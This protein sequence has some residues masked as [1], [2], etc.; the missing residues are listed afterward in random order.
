[1][2]DGQLFGPGGKTTPEYWIDGL[3]IRV[4]AKGA[5]AENAVPFPSECPSIP[6]SVCVPPRS[7]DLRRGSIA[8]IQGSKMTDSNAEHRDHY[9][10]G[11]RSL[12]G[13]VSRTRR[14]GRT[15]KR[16]VSDEFDGLHA[17][18]K[19]AVKGALNRCRVLTGQIE[20][21]LRNMSPKHFT[22][23]VSMADFLAS[24]ERAA[25][26]LGRKGRDNT[27]KPTVKGSQARGGQQPPLMED[28]S[29]S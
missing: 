4:A 5:T 3:R 21:K 1:M 28:E 29:S 13:Y 15:S 8:R 9:S 6:K 20:S 11:T 2:L 26:V 14:S 22:D 27:P 12:R 25:D 24:L 19:A 17:I 10:A 7:T 16:A 23:K 18:E